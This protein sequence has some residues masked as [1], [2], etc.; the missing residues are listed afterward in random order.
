MSTIVHRRSGGPC[1]GFLSRS[2]PMTGIDDDDDLFESGIVNSCCR[3]ADDVHREDLTASRWRWRTSRSR[4]SSRSNATTRF[5]LKKRR[6][7][8]AA[9]ADEQRA[10]HGEVQGVRRLERRAPP[11]SMDR[12]QRLPQAVI[13]SLARCGTSAAACRA[14]TGGQAGTRSPSA[15]STRP[16]AGGAP[17]YRRAHGA[18]DGFSMALLKWGTQEARQRWLP[19]LARGD[20]MAAFA[21]TDPA[22]AG[23]AVARHRVTP[24]PHA[25]C[26]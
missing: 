5:V 12:E 2:V 11:P 9:V 13:G 10:R 14:T 17:P 22:P 3:Q 8:A 4:T 23:A 19:P 6:G 26:S 20:T 18:G 24:Q 16:S 15:C 25:S 1:G 21:L 7:A